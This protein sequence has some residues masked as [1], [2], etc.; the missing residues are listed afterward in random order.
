MQCKMLAWELAK[1][2]ITWCNNQVDITMLA[3][4][5]KNLY[6]QVDLD[7]KVQMRDGDAEGA[8][9]YLCGKSKM[10]PSFYYK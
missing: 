9:A 8:L 10:D 6:N 3:S 4:Q 7:R 2:W 1:L 5:K